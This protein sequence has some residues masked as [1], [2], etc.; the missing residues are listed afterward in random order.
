MATDFSFRV[1]SV[2][3]AQLSPKRRRRSKKYIDKDRVES[4]AGLTCESGPRTSR[5]S[6]GSGPVVLCS[7]AYGLPCGGTGPD[8]DIRTPKNLHCSKFLFFFVLS[9]TRA[10]VDVRKGKTGHKRPVFKHPRLG[11]FNK[12]SPRGKVGNKSQ[13]TLYERVG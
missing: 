5:R 6:R 12:P 7:Y 4:Y 13:T 3:D 11:I 9:S 2:G 1:H 8:P 10:I